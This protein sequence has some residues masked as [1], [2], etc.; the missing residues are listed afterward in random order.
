MVKHIVGTLLLMALIS[1]DENQ[2]CIF[3]QNLEMKSG[4][5]FR[6]NHLLNGT[7]FLC[8]KD[9]ELRD[10]ICF[11]DGYMTELISFGYENEEISRDSYTKL[12]KVRKSTLFYI[13]SQEGLVNSVSYL[14]VGDESD[15][16][17]CYD[18]IKNHFTKKKI[19]DVYV[20]KGQLEEWK[21]L[22]W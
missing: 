5:Y 9:S 12:K 16:A 22:S 17:E 13:D 10:K 7:Y 21:K 15:T 19:P 6:G 4:V 2:E 1:C 20:A 3:K 8:N 18:F 11:E 14:I